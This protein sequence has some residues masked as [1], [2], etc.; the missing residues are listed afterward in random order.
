MEQVNKIRSLLLE[1][2][3]LSEAQEVVTPF[4]ADK[5]D[6]E[7]FKKEDDKNSIY[8]CCHTL[9]CSLQ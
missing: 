8:P 7:L 6:D 2:G 1:C 3:L 4:T 9:V 5:A